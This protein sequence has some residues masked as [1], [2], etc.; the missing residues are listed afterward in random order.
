MSEHVMEPELGAGRALSSFSKMAG[1][2][3]GIYA[4]S[5]SAD[6]RLQQTDQVGLTLP[7]KTTSEA[8]LSLDAYMITDRDFEDA[9]K[10]LEP[11]LAEAEGRTS[12][13]RVN[14]IYGSHRCYVA[15][16]AKRRKLSGDLYEPLVQKLSSSPV[17][18]PKSVSFSS[19][20]GRKLLNHFC[21][22]P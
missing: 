21:S 6:V 3:E 4:S 19:R 9:L 16:P 20:H 22:Q 2:G 11:L 10:Q 12:S 18:C 7:P 8:K 5:T 17:I 13:F 15:P 14:T 1:L